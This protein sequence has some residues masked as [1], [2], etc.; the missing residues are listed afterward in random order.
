MGCPRP[1]V[2]TWER[3]SGSG[4][5]HLTRGLSGSVS[6]HFPPCGGPQSSVTL[7]LGTLTPVFV[8]TEFANSS[9]GLDPGESWAFSIHPRLPRPPPGEPGNVT[10]RTPGTWREGCLS[11]FSAAHH[12]GPRGCRPTKPLL[13]RGGG[14]IL[15]WYL[16][17]TL[18]S[19]CEGGD[20]P[21]PPGTQHPGPSPPSSRA[22]LIPPRLQGQT[23]RTDG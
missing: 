19:V 13:P 10:G 17:Q 9:L 21:P 11:P 3:A 4:P 7:G 18:S 23:H 8:F 20:P 12:G 2:P 22:S 1:F 14:F 5:R 16:V 15:S 6:L